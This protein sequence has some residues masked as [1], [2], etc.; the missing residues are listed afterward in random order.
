MSKLSELERI[1]LV[2][3][4]YCQRKREIEAI[5]G[6][7][8]DDAA[9]LATLAEGEAIKAFEA[10]PVLLKMLEGQ[11]LPDKKICQMAQE[12]QD[13]IDHLDERANTYLKR[14]VKLFQLT[15]LGLKWERMKREQMEE[16]YVQYHDENGQLR[17]QLANMENREKWYLQFITANIDCSN[18]P[19]GDSCVQARK[20]G[21]VFEC[22][23]VISRQCREDA[24]IE[25]GEYYG[26][27]KRQAGGSIREA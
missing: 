12:A 26:R 6:P 25:E 22:C 27:W 24:I 14:A 19:N 21:E 1:R 2:W 9:Y 4:S 23:D 17:D 18:C 11:F 10:L 8:S 7:A 15:I 16:L 5:R 3:E 13:I 20:Q